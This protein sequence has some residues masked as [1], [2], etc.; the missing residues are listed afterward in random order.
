MKVLHCL[1]LNTQLIKPIIQPVPLGY[2]QPSRLQPPSFK[3]PHIKIP[4][5][6]TRE[7]QALEK[8]HSHIF[9][10]VLYSDFDTS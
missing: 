9:P 3:A 8:S 7:R 2:S 5:P 10:L 4:H 6:S 1:H